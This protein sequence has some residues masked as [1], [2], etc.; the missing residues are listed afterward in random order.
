MP[1]EALY[2]DALKYNWINC[3]KVGYFKL[4]LLAKT[5]NKTDLS[6]CGQQHICYKWSVPLKIPP[7]AVCHH[8]GA[9]VASQR[10]PIGPDGGG[11]I[12]IHAVALKR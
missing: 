3:K 7:Y 10:C 2:I 9:R 11:I 1:P 12:P 8:Q 4:S 5:M 6:H